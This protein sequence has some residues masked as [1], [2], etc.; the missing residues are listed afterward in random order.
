MCIF[1]SFNLVRQKVSNNGFIKYVCYPLV[2]IF[3]TP[4]YLLHMFSLFIYVRSKSLDFVCFTYLGDN[5]SWSE[6]SQISRPLSDDLVILVRLEVGL[7]FGLG[8]LDQLP[9]VFLKLLLAF[10]R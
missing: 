9:F 6:R 5:C 10:S 3:P 7:E 8:L 2:I 1:L 4:N